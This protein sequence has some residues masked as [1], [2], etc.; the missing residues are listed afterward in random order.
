[1]YNPL[2]EKGL[3]LEQQFR[4]WR[5]VNTKPYN[6]DE[7]HPYT[8]TAG[9][10]MNGIEVEGALF[11]HQFARHTDDMKL[12]KRL[13]MVRRIEQQQQKMINWMIPGDE[14]TLNVTVGYEQVAVDLTAFLAQNEK[15]PYVKQALDFA[16]LEDF[17]HLYR[18][19]NLMKLTMDMPANKV[20]KDLTEITVGRPTFLEHRYPEDDVRKFADKKTCDMMTCL[21]IMTIIAA[22]QQTMNYYMNVGNRFEDMLSRGL[23]Q[24]I[25]QIEEQHVTHYES[26]MDPRTSWL[27]Q[28]FMHEMTECWLY[29]S[30]MEHAYDNMSHQVFEQML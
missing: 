30:L 7:V 3:P 11:M 13:A 25:A 23:Y 18:Y 21:H 22:E 5:E 1:M 17:D 10:L 29:Y 27:E 4:P 19:S 14:P 15:D 6:K 12:K 16:L 24:E 2:K 20:T 8:R 9:I 26:L 28:W